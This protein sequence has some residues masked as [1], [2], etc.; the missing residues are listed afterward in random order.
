MKEENLKQENL[1]DDGRALWSN[2]TE[3][4]SSDFWSNYE[5]LLTQAR[6]TQQFRLQAI[7]DK[8][9]ELELQPLVVMDVSKASL[10]TN[11]M[12]TQP[13]A[14]RFL[15]Q[16]YLAMLVLLGIFSFSMYMYSHYTQGND[17][18]KKEQWIYTSLNKRERRAFDY[19]MNK[20]EKL[21]GFTNRGKKLNYLI[22]KFNLVDWSKPPINL[23]D[24]TRKIYQLFDPGNLE[25]HYTEYKPGRFRRIIKVLEKYYLQH[26]IDDLEEIELTEYN[27]YRAGLTLRYKGELVKSDYYYYRKNVFKNAFLFKVEDPAYKKEKFEKTVPYLHSYNAIGER[28]SIENN[29]LIDVFIK[30]GMISR[31]KFR[32]NA[33]D[34]FE[35]QPSADF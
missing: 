7:V 5:T 27:V 23:N 9:N 12:A 33:L 25:I 19:L 31:N 8:E 34:L 28:I 30:T 1:E 2:F 35:E 17:S 4:N 3:N 10:M 14:K 18:K 20:E 21:H 26:S 24:T 32:P 29:H 6:N 11:A 16:N 13:L 15:R 22:Y